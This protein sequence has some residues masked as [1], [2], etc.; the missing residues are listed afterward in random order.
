[1]LHLISQNSGFFFSYVSWINSSL[2]L[3]FGDK[4]FS[5]LCFVGGALWIHSLK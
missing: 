1:M 5:P 2:S 3:Y 4:L